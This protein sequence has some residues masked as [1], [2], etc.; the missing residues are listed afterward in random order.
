MAISPS[1]HFSRQ[2]VM[3][4]FNVVNFNE[5]RT[6]VPVK[7]FASVEKL[8]VVKGARTVDNQLILDMDEPE[9]DNPEVVRTIVEA[10][11]RVQYVTELRSTLE[12]VYLKMIK[13]AEDQ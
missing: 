13:E 6:N 7:L 5:S 12:D 9:R 8:H 10:G 11:G 4:T 1:D 3:S 2:L